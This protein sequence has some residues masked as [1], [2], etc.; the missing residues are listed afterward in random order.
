VDLAAGVATAVAISP[1][2]V[3]AREGARTIVAMGLGMSEAA[4]RAAR[5]TVLNVSQEFNLRAPVPRAAAAE[6]VLASI[7]ITDALAAR[8][9]LPVVARAATSA[10]AVAP[11]GLAL[12]SAG[13]IRQTGSSTAAPAG[14]RRAISQ[15][16]LALALLALPAWWAGFLLLVCLH[17]VA[18]RCGVVP[19]LVAPLP[20]L[21]GLAAFCVCF[22]Q[23]KEGRW[24]AEGSAQQHLRQAPAGAD[25]A[26]GAR[27]G[28]EAGS[29]HGECSLTMAHHWA[30]GVTC[31]Y[32]GLRM[33]CLLERNVVEQYRHD[34]PEIRR[35]TGWMGTWGTP[36]SSRR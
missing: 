32:C 24:S 11:T 23:G 25:A 27:Q 35:A 15:L 33:M 21:P 17:A 30:A 10:A 29:V 8:A 34:G 22:V 2:A 9:A 20:A 13:L 19:A 5:P 31:R 28:I 36:V 26:E 12:A 1:P 14:A 3:A 7:L 16:P 18:V 6:F 4:H